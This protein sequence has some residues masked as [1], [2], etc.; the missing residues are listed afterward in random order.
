MP[1]PTRRSS[2]WISCAERKSA[3]RS[4]RPD[5]AARWRVARIARV[6]AGPPGWGSRG[7]G[8]RGWGSSGWGRWGLGL[9][10][11]GLVGLGLVGLG[12]V[13][14]GLVGLGLARLGPGPCRVVRPAH[15]PSAAWA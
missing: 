8:S 9:V 10:G 5:T 7:W 15:V 3:T 11:L 1:S 2:S 14:L 4:S 6:A 12:L 13:G